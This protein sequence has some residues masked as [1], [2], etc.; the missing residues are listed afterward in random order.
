MTFELF[1]VI[2]IMSGGPASDVVEL[3]AL[4]ASFVLFVALIT[5]QTGLQRYCFPHIS[6]VLEWG[7]S[8]S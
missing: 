2:I 3:E 1:F 4:P 6:S 8:V 5:R 7:G